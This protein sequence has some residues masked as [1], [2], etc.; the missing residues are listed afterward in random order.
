MDGR[1][2]CS[3][4]MRWLILSCSSLLFGTCLPAFAD[5]T[6]L[7]PGTDEKVAALDSLEL[8]DFSSQSPI[9]PKTFLPA[10]LEPAMALESAILAE[11]TPETPHA[12]PVA[13]T[14]PA[15]AQTVEAEPDEP[16]SPRWSVQAE[17]LFLDRDI[18]DVVTTVDRATDEEFG[19]DDLSFDLDTGIRWRIGY[20]FS[21]ANSVEFGGFGLINHQDVDSFTSS[22]LSPSGE[23]LRAAF[24]P[25]ATDP[26]ASNFAQTFRQSINY[27]AETTNLELNYRHTLPR[28]SGG[29]QGSLLAGLR[30][31][32]LTEDFR[33]TSTDEDPDIFPGTSVGRYRI[34][35][36]NDGIGLQ[37][38][39]DLSYQFAQNFDIAL[40]FRTG[41]LL[42]NASQDSEI[43][44]DLGG[45][46]VT[47]DG[48]GSNTEISPVVE[49]GAFLNWALS[50][51]VSLNA[52]YSFLLFGNMALA[53]EQFAGS[54]N[55]SDSL[56]GLDRGSV[57]YHGPSLGIQVRF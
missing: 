55:F 28:S 38:G 22:I 43:R 14:V 35:A 51:Q 56:S 16:A 42:N 45:Q 29:W 53:P 39:G 41:L 4:M 44:N 34:D 40:R 47:T 15:I 6:P 37:V 50:R 20:H 17:A 49:L 25:D 18:P 1:F 36:D 12:P 2:V 30:Y 24:N 19:T 11:G 52:G 7:S 10:E 26:E 46:T 31:L 33:L 3:M 57:I 9:S 27:S 48:D 23:V 8:S 13:G 5:D 32:S 21:P 54:N